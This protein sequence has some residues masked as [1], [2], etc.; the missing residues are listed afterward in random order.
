VFG[1][2]HHGENGH[3]S[4]REAE[5]GVALQVIDAHRLPRDMVDDT[6]LHRH[7]KREKNGPDDF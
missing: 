3:S 2:G 7:Q 6:V 5:A 1:G 4:I